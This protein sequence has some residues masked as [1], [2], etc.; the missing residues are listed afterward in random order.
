MKESKSDGSMA[1]LFDGPPK[2]KYLRGIPINDAVK[3]AEHCHQ[4]DGGERLSLKDRKSQTIHAFVTFQYLP[5]YSITGKSKID[6]G[7]FVRS[8]IVSSLFEL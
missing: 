4:T 2:K 1:D 3:K 5:G 8:Q 7:S 6:F